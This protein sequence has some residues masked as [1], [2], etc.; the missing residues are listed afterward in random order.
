MRQ[1]FDYSKYP[2]DR[3]DVWMRL[4]HNDFYRNVILV[5]DFDSY[6][7][8]RTDHKHGSEGYFVLEGWEIG[9]SQFSYRNWL[10]MGLYIWNISTLHST[11][12]MAPLQFAER[13][14]ETTLSANLSSPFA[15]RIFFRRSSLRRSES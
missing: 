7:N 12:L 6:T 15:S 13:Y 3:E 8:M 11:L 10:P 4:W 1:Q 2:F 5:P 9:D 14:P